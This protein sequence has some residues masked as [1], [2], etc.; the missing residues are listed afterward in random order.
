RRATFLAAAPTPLV[1][2]ERGFLTQADEPALHPDE[3]VGASGKKQRSGNEPLLH[4]D[5]RG[6][7]MTTGGGPGERE[8]S[9]CLLQ[10]DAEAWILGRIPSPLIQPKTCGQLAVFREGDASWR[11]F[12][13]DNV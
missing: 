8:G 7:G 4:P 13:C 1:G 12:P 3:R 2:V 11:P 9:R 6:G 5:K 10:F